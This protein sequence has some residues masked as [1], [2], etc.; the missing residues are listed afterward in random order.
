MVFVDK[1]PYQDVAVRLRVNKGLIARIVKA[2]KTDPT[3]VEQMVEKERSLQQK[4]ESVKDS[5][6]TLINRD[7]CI[8][9]ISVV[10]QHI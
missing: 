3:V 7:R 10:Q 2:Y 5:V 8:R 9:K 1:W 4:I 6:D